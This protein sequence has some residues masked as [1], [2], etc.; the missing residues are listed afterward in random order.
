MATF[1]GGRTLPRIRQLHQLDLSASGRRR[2]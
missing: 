2:S 1:L